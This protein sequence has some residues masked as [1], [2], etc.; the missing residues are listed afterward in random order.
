M[1]FFFFSISFFFIRILDNTVLFCKKISWIK[2][3]NNKE[4]KQLIIVS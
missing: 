4:E 2:Y 1:N 3:Q